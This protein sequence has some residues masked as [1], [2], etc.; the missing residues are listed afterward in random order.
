MSD[1]QG[2][3][4]HKQAWVHP[5]PRSPPPRSASITNPAPTGPNLHPLE[6]ASPFPHLLCLFGVLR[7][8][9]TPLGGLLCLPWASSE[10][11]NPASFQK[12]FLTSTTHPY[13]YIRAQEWPQQS[14]RR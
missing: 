5:P 1:C 2:Q 10:K 11:K 12:P 7:L 6:G 8:P 9:Q 13:K 3:V 14:L 4:K